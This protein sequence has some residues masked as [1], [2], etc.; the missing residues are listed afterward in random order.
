M[1]QINQ[2]YSWADLGFWA[3]AKNQ[4]FQHMAMLHT[5]EREGSM[6]QHA[7]KYCAITHTWGQN[8]N[9]CFPF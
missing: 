3:I 5:H 7:S 4:L 9:F 2:D 8:V 6:Q 1:K